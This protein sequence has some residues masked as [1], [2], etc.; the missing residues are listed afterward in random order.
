[1]NSNEIWVLLLGFTTWS[2]TGIAAE[3]ATFAT[4]D[5]ATAIITDCASTPTINTT[6]TADT[7]SCYGSGRMNLASMKKLPQF[8]FSFLY[9][10]CPYDCELSFSLSL[11]VS[12]FKLL[13]IIV[14]DMNN[15]ISIFNII[16][17]APW[18]ISSIPLQHFWL[19]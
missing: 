5:A 6:T 3:T 16:F 15:R 11:F 7:I 8:S 19:T 12:S 1:M 4:T 9:S 18:T 10:S 13:L 17:L 2:Q 14:Y